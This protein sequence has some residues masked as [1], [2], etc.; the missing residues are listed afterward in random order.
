M[1][2]PRDRLECD[3]AHRPRSLAGDE[4]REQ[5]H[6]VAGDRVLLAR[7]EVAEVRAVGIVRVDQA[8]P[9]RAAG[10][11]GQGELDDVGVGVQHRSSVASSPAA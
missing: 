8:E 4:A 2:S 7:L 10:E 6:G 9:P 11:R 1:A 3:P 5:Q